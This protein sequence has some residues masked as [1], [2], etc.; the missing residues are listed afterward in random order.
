MATIGDLPQQYRPYFKAMNKGIQRMIDI[1]FDV[2][3]SKEKKLEQISQINGM[4]PANI[5]MIEYYV[6]TGVA[7][8]ELEMDKVITEQTTP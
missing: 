7:D 4:I 3:L 6:Q 2:A 8:A 5:K 1:V